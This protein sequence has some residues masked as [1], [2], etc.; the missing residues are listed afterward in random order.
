VGSPVG[1]P[2]GETCPSTAQLQKINSKKVIACIDRILKF[3][4]LP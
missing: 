2:V 4:I 1:S 3:P